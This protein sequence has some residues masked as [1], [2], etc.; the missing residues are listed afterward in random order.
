M[1]TLV[2]Y[3]L[4]CRNEGL[5]SRNGARGATLRSHEPDKTHRPGSSRRSS[6]DWIGRRSN[7][8]IRRRSSELRN[9]FGNW[10]GDVS[11]CNARR[12]CSW[13]DTYRTGNPEPLELRGVPTVTFGAARPGIRSRPG[14]DH[15]Y[16]VRTKWCTGSL[17]LG[18]RA[19]SQSCHRRYQRF[20][21]D[22]QN[23]V[24]QHRGM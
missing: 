11:G 1:G 24:R 16:A 10:W 9:K 7:L 18:E 8:R 23:P 22:P 20:H 15:N 19:R 6:L 13:L 17:V 3:A 14:R 21:Q 12:A 4:S 5:K 2:S